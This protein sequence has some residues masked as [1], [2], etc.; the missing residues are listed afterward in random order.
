[1][2]KLKLNLGPQHPST[3]G[4]L[5]LILELNG[6][7]IISC[8]PDV[9]YLHRGMEKMA[10]NLKL[11][12]KIRFTGFVKEPEKLW[13]NCDVFFFPIRWQEPFGLVGLEAVHRYEERRAFHSVHRWRQGCCLIFS[14]CVEESPS[15]GL[16]QGQGEGA[17]GRFCLLFKDDHSSGRI[18]GSRIFQWGVLC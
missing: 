13:A 5:R 9:G 16:V 4:V 11:T 2:T 6:E 1:M 8:E 7:K 18:Q 17:P 15:C 12:D 3:H 14:D 10:E